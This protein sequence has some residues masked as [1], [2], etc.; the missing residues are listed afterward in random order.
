[1]NSDII[2]SIKIIIASVLIVM[3]LVVVNNC[4]KKPV[5]ESD[6]DDT[7]E[8]IIRISGILN[9]NSSNFNR[10]GLFYSHWREAIRTDNS[11]P[12]AITTVSGLEWSLS[13]PDITK[14]N[15]FDNLEFEGSSGGNPIYGFFVVGWSDI[16]GDGKFDPISGEPSGF[17]HINSDTIE[18]AMLFYIDDDSNLPIDNWQVSTGELKDNTD[19]WFIIDDSQAE[20]ISSWIYR[21]STYTVVSGLAEQR[22]SFE[23]DPVDG[24]TVWLTDEDITCLDT[25][26]NPLHSGTWINVRFPEITTRSY[27][28]LEVMGFMRGW[29]G[30]VQSNID[31][32]LGRAG[33]VFVDTLVEKRIQGWIIFEEIGGFEEGEI[34]GRVYGTFD[35]PFCSAV[36]DT[37]YIPKE[38][39]KSWQYFDSEIPILSSLA[40]IQVYDGYERLEIVFSDQ[41]ITCTDAP[42]PNL[43]GSSLKVV[44][45]NFASKIYDG[46]YLS[47]YIRLPSINGGYNLRGKA[48][49][50]FADTTAENRIKGWLAIDTKQY[51]PNIKIFG[52]FDVSFC[53]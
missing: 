16:D 25:P 29:R 53:P 38:S 46:T 10:V 11:V 19:N 44:F 52:T 50:T 35:V 13:I 17:G 43:P 8:E 7:E 18:I 4:E 24:I 30:I 45:P 20:P 37:A 14:D 51:F 32:N 47:G 28:E 39:I 48:G 3:T 21:D 49:I 9:P 2:V 23:G 22:R 26:I 34:T 40:Q 36:L 15:A 42:F 27:G 6:L 5:T 1:M 31:G 12:F 41:N 33:L